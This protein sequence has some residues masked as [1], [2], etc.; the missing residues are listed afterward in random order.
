MA[1]KKKRVKRRAK[2]KVRRPAATAG[3]PGLLAQ[4]KA[5]HAD[6]DAR[7]S[8]LQ[9]EME[10][11][12][13]AIGAMEGVAPRAGGAAVPGAARRGPRPAG[14]SLKDFIIK[15][16]GRTSGPMTVKDLG[17]AILRAGYQTKSRNLGNQISMALAQLTRARK[18]KKVGR[19]MYKT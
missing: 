17:A 12:A 7:V 15:V 16:L 18:V 9:S 11:V 10:G 14:T 6:L 1:R 2:R 4:L 19:G 5:Y 8:A 13:T 3:S